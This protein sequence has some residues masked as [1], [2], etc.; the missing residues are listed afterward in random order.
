MTQ[1][2]QQIFADFRKK[3]KP[4]CGRLKKEKLEFVFGKRA[5]EIG[6]SVILPIGENSAKGLLVFASFEESRFNPEMSTDLLSKLSLILDK[7]LS[8]TF[9]IDDESKLE[10]NESQ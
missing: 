2:F 4:I 1:E 9:A 3:N 10:N 8:K 6:S 7:K 5:D